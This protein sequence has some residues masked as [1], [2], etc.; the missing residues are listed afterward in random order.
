MCLSPMLMTPR[1]GSACFRRLAMPLPKS[2]AKKWPT[3]W[4][5]AT[6]EPSSNRNLCL[7]FPGPCWAATVRLLGRSGYFRRRRPAFALCS[8]PRVGHPPEPYS[9]VGWCH[10]RGS[11]QTMIQQKLKFLGMLFVLSILTAC[12]AKSSGGVGST[13][14]PTATLSANP[15]TITAGQQSSAL[16]FTSTNATT[17]SIDNGVGPVGINSHVSVSPTQTTTYTYTA[18]GPGGSATAQ[19][20]V[21]VTPLP[22]PTATLSANP[23]TI[24]AGQQSSTLTFTSTNATTGSIDNGVGPVG[25]NSHVSVSPTVTTTYT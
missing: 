9:M 25:I 21:T 19:A 20:T 16:T 7:I 24:T 1:S 14:A 3:L 10:L 5:K 17:G 6:R 13:P 15:S 4:S 18:T 12:G 8:P 23:G 11:C 22:L 2:A